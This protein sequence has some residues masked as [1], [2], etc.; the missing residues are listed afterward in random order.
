MKI[1]GFFLNVNKPPIP[2]HNNHHQSPTNSLRLRNAIK[3]RDCNYWVSF[4]ETLF[5]TK[6]GNMLTIMIQSFDEADTM[7]TA[8]FEGS[9]SKLILDNGSFCCKQA[10]N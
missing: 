2:V 4:Y 9:I 7:L 10:K 3:K 8:L 1:S 6:L 5:S